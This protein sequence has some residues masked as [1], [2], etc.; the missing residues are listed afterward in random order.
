MNPEPKIPKDDAM[1]AMA[2]TI[3]GVYDLP[4]RIQLLS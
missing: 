1:K 2:R 3:A 4:S